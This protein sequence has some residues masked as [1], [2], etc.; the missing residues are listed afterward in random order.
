MS[1]RPS[2]R[3]RH[4][5]DVVAAADERAAAV[6]DRAVGAAGAVAAE[7]FGPYPDTSQVV[8]GEIAP[9]HIDGYAVADFFDHHASATDQS[10]QHHGEDQ[11]GTH[12]HASRD[13]DSAA[14]PEVPARGPASTPRA[15]PVTRDRDRDRDQE[16]AALALALRRT[17]TARDSEMT[18]VAEAFG[19]C[20]ARIKRFLDPFDDAAPNQI[21]L[22]R[23]L[24][25]D[26]ELHDEYKR[27]TERLFD[28]DDVDSSPSSIVL[29]VL[30]ADAEAADVS[31]VT[32]GALTDKHTPGVI[33]PAE[34]ADG[35]K[36]CAEAIAKMTNVQRKLEQIVRGRR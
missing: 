14:Q 20:V 15:K 17:M 11:M 9:F 34:A 12:V 31:R 30:E 24:V 4:A 16:N 33:T 6:A 7:R 1:R 28:E 23:C 5:R 13:T 21:H 29:A 10:N 22:A 26:R 32:H 2:A 25:R 36:E 3:T 35:I 18:E 8:V 19:V 27:Q